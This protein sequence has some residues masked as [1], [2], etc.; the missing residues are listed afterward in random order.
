VPDPSPAST[1]GGWLGWNNCRMSH[2]DREDLVS[3]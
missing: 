3:G 1:I 2:A